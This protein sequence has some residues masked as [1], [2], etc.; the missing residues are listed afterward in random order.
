MTVKEIIIEKL[1]KLGADGLNCNE[2]DECGCGFNNLAECGEDFSD[3]IPAKED[4]GL[5]YP[6]GGK[7]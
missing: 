3:C 4:C 5:F 1:K 7:Q 6:L 2:K